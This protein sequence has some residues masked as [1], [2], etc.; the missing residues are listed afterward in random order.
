M[1]KISF[2][3]LLS[4]VFL[5][6]SCIKE[7]LPNC[8][9]DILTINIDKSLLKYPPIINNSDI[10]CYVKTETDLTNLAPTFT[11]T[12]GAKILPESGTQRD[13]T[14]P[15]K[16][17]VTSEDKNWQKTYTIS[18]ISSDITR[19]YHFDHY[20]IKEGKYAEIYE[21]DTD[22]NKNMVWAS[23][24]IGF[25][26]VAGSLP[27][28]SYPTSSYP[29]GFMNRAVKLLTCSTGAFGM[30]N[31]TPIAAGNLFMGEFELDISNPLKS[32]HFG[33]PITYEPYLLKGHYKYTS[34]EIFKR[35]TD[36]NGNYINDGE[37]LDRK[38]SCSVYAVFYETDENTPFLDG[39]NVLTHPNI[40]S[41]AQVQNMGET[42]DWTDFEA[43]FVMKEGKIID[44][45]KLQDGKYH[46]SIVFSSSKD[47]NLYNG[48]IGS[49]LLVDEVEVILR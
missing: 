15:Q 17:T 37:I 36:E 16:Y 18:I 33:M 27:P 49:T 20:E 9:A 8:E 12:E 25:S 24:N 14:S 5:L 28:E 6:N 10:V 46:L 32:T 45:Q 47:G 13:F 48:A 44:K 38:D 30:A 31:H 29:D 41:L 40:L 34:G 22:G 4:I 35:Y 23:G 39:T 19:E 7:E 43:R 3:F 11:I 21:V 1:K 42:E 26:F 2:I